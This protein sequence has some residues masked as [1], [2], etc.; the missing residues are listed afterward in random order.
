MSDITCSF[1]GTT[2]PHDKAKNRM[3]AGAEAFICRGCAE[4]CI[5]VFATSDPEWRDQQLAKLTE[6]RE[7]PQS[8]N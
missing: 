1:C 6:L 3:V 2:M 4:I 7:K 8:S 5:H